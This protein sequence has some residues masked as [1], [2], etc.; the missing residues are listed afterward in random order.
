MMESKDCSY[1]KHNADLL[2]RLALAPCFPHGNDA[3]PANHLHVQH[4]TFMTGPED[5]SPTQTTS[6]IVVV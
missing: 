1:D 3:P 6:S 4:A 2:S 5:L